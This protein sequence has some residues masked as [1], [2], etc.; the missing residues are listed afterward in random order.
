LFSVMK[1][2]KYKNVTKILIINMIFLG[3]SGSF[4]FESGLK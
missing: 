2:P 4:A 1:S 3:L